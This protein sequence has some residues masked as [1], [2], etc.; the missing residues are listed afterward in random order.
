[1]FT[2][3]IRQNLQALLVGIGIISVAGL[4]SAVLATIDDSKHVI[5]KYFFFALIITTSFF[6]DSRLSVRTGIWGLSGVCYLICGIPIFFPK[7]FGS[8]RTLLAM[9]SICLLLAL[10]VGSDTGLKVSSYGFTLSIPV[11]LANF[12]HFRQLFFFRPKV[13][14]D[15]YV[16][17]FL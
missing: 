16:P 6:V 12:I 4:F 11:V 8:E 14:V 17:L 5:I 10:S 2:R 9:V 1:M 13:V 15:R 3:F 7:R